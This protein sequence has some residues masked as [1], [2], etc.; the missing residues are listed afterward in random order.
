VKI[1]LV[2]VATLMFI[3]QQVTMTLGTMPTV[4]V[5][6]PS[7]TPKVA[8]YVTPLGMTKTMKM[9]LFKVSTPIA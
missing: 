5:S 3:N 4:C 6:V 8:T 7:M 9:T 2:A 1:D